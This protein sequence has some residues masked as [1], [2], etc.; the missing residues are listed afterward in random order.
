[1]TLQRTSWGFGRIALLLS[2]SWILAVGLFFYPKWK[3]SNTEATLGWDVSGYYFYL[4]AIF[5]YHD[6]KEQKFKDSLLAKYNPTSSPYQSYQYKNGSYV[7]KYSAGME[8][9]YSPFF[10]T[11]HLLAKP[12]GYEPNGFSYPYQLAIGWGSLI[13]AITGLIFLYKILRV[14]FSSAVTGVVLLL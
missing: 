11:A 10:F 5:I 7:M 6:L 9:R 13:I 3:Y 1:M 14:F 8:V 12:M 2:V 4:P